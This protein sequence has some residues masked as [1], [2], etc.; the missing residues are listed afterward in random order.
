MVT[1]ICTEHTDPFRPVFR[2]PPPDGVVELIGQIDRSRGI[3]ELKDGSLMAAGRTAYRLSRDG[4]RTW[5]APVA[6][7]E[8]VVGDGL[9]RNRHHG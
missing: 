9:R 8:G 6:F 3:I 4:G 2:K 5:A 7:P 1:P